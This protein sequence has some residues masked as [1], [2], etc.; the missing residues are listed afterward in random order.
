MG[1]CGYRIPEAI[2]LRDKEVP[3]ND[4]SRD[5]C[6][7]LSLLESSSCNYLYSATELL[8]FWEVT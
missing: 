1:F 4:T 5:C 8:D 2:T 7:L 6:F 3:Q